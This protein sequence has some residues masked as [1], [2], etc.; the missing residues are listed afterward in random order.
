[1]LIYESASGSSVFLR[2]SGALGALARKPR[3]GWLLA[4][5]VTV[6]P[7]IQGAEAGPKGPAEPWY[8]REL[9]AEISKLANELREPVVALP[10]VRAALR[11][12]HQELIGLDPELRQEFERKVWAL[13]LVADQHEHG[14]HDAPSR[15]ASAASPHD[16][17]PAGRHTSCREALVGAR[18]ALAEL[19][20]GGELWI[21]ASADQG[22]EWTHVSTT[23][24]DFDTTI[25]VWSGCPEQGGSK[26]AVADDERGLLAE[27]TVAV[28]PGEPRWL[29]VHGWRGVGGTLVVTLNGS[30]G[31][32][33]GR[34]VRE[35]TQAP[36][37]QRFVRVWEP[38]GNF[39]GAAQVDVGGGYVV[40]GLAPGPYRVSTLTYPGWSLGLLDE[41][42]DDQACPGGVPTG[43]DL[44]TGAP[45]VV[46]AGEATTGID[47]SLAVGGRIA[48]RILETGTN[49]PIAGVL[50]SA[51]NPAGG[52]VAAATTD[53]AGRYLLAGLAGEVFVTA[54]ASVHLSEIYDDIPCGIWC[55]PTTGTALQTV[56][57]VTIAGIDFSLRRYGAIAGRVTH[58]ATGEPIPG[59]VVGVSG[60]SQ[61]TVSTDSG[62][63]YLVGGLPPGKY[64]VSTQTYGAYEDEVWD[65][66]P[67]PGACVPSSGD[68]VVV[69]SEATTTG[70]DFVLDRRGGI[71]GF[72]TDILSGE[73][74]NG[75]RV[76]VLDVASSFQ[77]SVYTSNGTYS[78]AGLRPGNYKVVVLDPNYRGMLYDGVDCPASVAT[79]CPLALGTAVQVLPEVVTSGINFSLQPLGRLSGTVATSGSPIY[80]YRIVVW[81]V[82]GEYVK[83]KHF[84]TLDWVL[85]GIAPGDYYVTVS[86]PGYAG[87]LFDNLPCLAGSPS[88]CDPGGLATVV[89]ATSGSV[90][91][92]IDFVLDPMG[93]ITG[94][95]S[96]A[97][98]GV[99]VSGI[100]EVFDEAGLLVYS[101]AAQGAYAVTGL[102]TGNYHVKGSSYAHSS[103]LYDD[104]PCPTL[105]DVTAGTSVPVVMGSITTGVDIALP[106]N[107]TIQG[108]A[109]SAAGPMPPAVKVAVADLNG[110]DYDSWW[111]DGGGPY[112]IELAEGTYYVM[113]L[114]Q[115]GHF[116]DQIFNGIDCPSSGCTLDLATPVVVQAG[117]TT[118]AID[119]ALEPLTGIVGQV[120][121]SQ[122]QPVPGVA[123]DLWSSTGAWLASATTGPNGRYRLTANG[124]SFFVSTDN[125]M[126]ALDELWLGVACP[127][128]PA[129]LG[130]CNPLDGDVVKLTSGGLVTGIDFVLEG[131]PI[132]LDG[133][134][135]GDTSTWSP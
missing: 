61:R 38:N 121:D 69:T 111:I 115:G 73:P 116:Q 92:G 134:E 13:S 19:A 60:P 18:G 82:A 44:A 35:D 64:F 65:G 20:P 101:G 87:E 42:Y 72:V 11:R 62:G 70:I 22:P 77:S 10:T 114:P 76:D 98:D 100:V 56:G 80:Y 71:A 50:V 34:A 106:A 36:L 55:H 91:T 4:A 74:V 48:G 51:Y 78:V 123:I 135:S 67:C 83:E 32:I 1:M 93:S 2:L 31:T 105:C 30:A 120:V 66:V 26:L 28:A 94:V 24:S 117:A 40:G 23:G 45:V 112:N 14:R 84:W 89:T 75:A 124:G 37:T 27:I 3:A 127:F 97:S 53:G 16:R 122:D 132:F 7:M 86:H 63:D 5:A 9:H 99:A 131:V 96:R 128:G 8:G 47:I 130:L 79:A 52:L 103:R 46:A 133:F 125:G 54:E 118:S 57:G 58:A 15:P 17:V 102:P 119:F 6:A 25:E 126:G 29:R 108:N 113:A 90:T 41:L 85:G 21:R 129:Y 59:A 88:V 49:L 33:S 39:A 95:L 12:H 104:V 109:G 110:N 68:A 107:G 43:C 81:T